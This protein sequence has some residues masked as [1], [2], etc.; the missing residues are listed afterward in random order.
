MQKRVIGLQVQHTDAKSNFRSKVWIEKWNQNAKICVLRKSLGLSEKIWVICFR[1]LDLTNVT[2]HFRNCSLDPR[3]RTSFAPFKLN[4]AKNS[5]EQKALAE[6]LYLSVFCFNF[7]NTIFETPDRMIY[8]K[9]VPVRL[10][11]PSE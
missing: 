9:K 6:K 1:V 3:C 11:N 4:G 10:K 7:P 2:L 5:A 8:Y